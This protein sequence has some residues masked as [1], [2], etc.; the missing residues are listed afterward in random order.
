MSDRLLPWLVPALITAAVLPASSQVTI[1]LTVTVSPDRAVLGD[2]LAIVVNASEQPTVEVAGTALPVFSIGPQQW[3]AFVATTP[4][5][6]PGRRS[7]IVRAGNEIR[8]MLLWVGDRSFPVQSI[9][10]PPGKDSS[11]TDLEFDRVDAFKALVTSERL[12]QGAFRRPNSGPVTTP[13]GVRRYYNG[14]F[15]KDYFHCGLDFAGPKGSPVV[16]AQWGRVALV[17]RESQGFLVH[18]NTIGIDHGQGVL[19]IYLHLDQI[20][21]QE[22]Q[23]VEAGQV[24]GTVGNTGASTGPH[25][26]WGLYVNGECVDPR[27]WLAQGW[28]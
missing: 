19:T 24:I 20:R 11:G 3:R 23:M 10:L 16:A 9:W 4:L 7:L 6:T 25:L 18:G 21:V 28:Q 8:N 15:A 2:T 26:H 27:S 22:G 1:P 5:Q 14:V 13:Y 17:G 12:W